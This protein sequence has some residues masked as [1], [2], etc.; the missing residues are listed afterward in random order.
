MSDNPGRLIVIDYEFGDFEYYVDGSTF[1]LDHDVGEFKLDHN[2][3]LPCVS[4]DQSFA[5]MWTKKMLL[6]TDTIPQLFEEDYKFLDLT[7][8]LEVMME[9]PIRK[10]GLVHILGDTYKVL[11]LE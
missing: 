4:E 3:V 9:Y 1:Y 5:T 6:R 11:P 7:F 10:Y 8:T 2:R